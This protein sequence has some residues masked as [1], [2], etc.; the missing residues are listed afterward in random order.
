M[1]A[2]RQMGIHKRG[3][4]HLRPHNSTRSALQPDR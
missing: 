2:D 1:I 3:N 4:G